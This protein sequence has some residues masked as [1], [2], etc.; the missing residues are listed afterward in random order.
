VNKTMYGNKDKKGQLFFI[1]C[2]IYIE[3]VIFVLYLTAEKKNSLAKTNQEIEDF[4]K[5][6]EAAKEVIIRMSVFKVQNSQ[7]ITTPITRKS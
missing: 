7:S 3:N 5:E 2:S 6:L 1:N 4:N